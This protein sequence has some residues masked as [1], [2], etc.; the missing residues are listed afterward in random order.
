M[1]ISPP[2]PF[3]ALLI[4]PEDGTMKGG[5]RMTV[6]LLLFSACVGWILAYKILESR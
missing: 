3:R 1:K 5:Q 4:F 2:M 6:D